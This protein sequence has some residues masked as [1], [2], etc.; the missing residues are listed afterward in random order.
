M[1]AR[2][3]HLAYPTLS[4]CMIVKNEEKFL[5][6][7]L[8]SIKDAVDEIIIVDTGSTD[9]TVEIA[10]RYTDK[11]YFYAWNNSFS[12]ARNVSLGYA[13]GEWILQID[14]DEKLEQEDVPLLHQVIQSNQYDVVF[15]TILNELP[16]GQW[17]KHRF[18][19]LFR[20]GRAH[21]EGIVHNQLVYDGP[22]AVAEIRL[23]HYGYNLTPEQMAAKYERTTG[24]L[25]QQIADDPM[26]TFA[27]QNLVHALR[28][29]EDY[30]EMIAEGKTALAVD[31]P[32]TTP[33]HRQQIK[34]DMAYAYLQLGK[35]SEAE[36]LCL[37]VL[38]EVPFFLDAIFNQATTYMVW[39]KTDTAIR[40]F[41][42]FLE[43]KRD[44]ERHP[45]FS[46]LIVDVYDFESRVY[47]NLG[48][49]YERLAELE[50]A[51]ASYR[52][53][54]A[55]DAL[56]LNPYI[57]L[58]Q[59]FVQQDSTAEAITTLE[60][61]RDVGI[62]AAQLHFFLGDLYNRQGLFARAEAMFRE[63]TTVEENADVYNGL[64][65]ALLNQNRLEDADAAAKRGLELAADHAGLWMTRAHIAA[66]RG[67]AHA[68]REAAHHLLSVHTNETLLFPELTYLCTESGEYAT[69]IRVIERYLETAAPNAA[70]LSDLAT[71]YVKQGQLQAALTGYRAA[72]SLD[73]HCKP[74]IAN[75][76]Q[77]QTQ[78][79]S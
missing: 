22:A 27:R 43:V 47:L 74:A 65:I 41:K 30:E 13:T 55:Y 61:A 38:E 25:R 11:V 37:E 48:V 6:Q 12:E 36:A 14:A 39:G 40:Y 31:S 16:G 28:G 20:R 79:R 19:R 5:A 72:L 46:Q 58:A 1:N 3:K 24:L 9:R 33:T 71:C 56:F 69:A 67:D 64:A 75:L 34:T 15:V 51:V 21:Y 54:I 42:K 66:R 49:C 4:A 57:G 18:Q 76:R 52:Q 35:Y 62:T 29:V 77:L 32:Q 26:N 63:A 59:L 8:D 44:E 50:K 78:L 10:R 17:G 68:V 45:H 7:C 60:R 53:A 2:N 70:I 73:P 23:Y